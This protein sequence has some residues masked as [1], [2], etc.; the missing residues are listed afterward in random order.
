MYNYCSFG[1]Q[2]QLI[3]SEQCLKQGGVEDK[4]ISL[5]SLEGKIKSQDKSV[6]ELTFSP[7]S[8]HV[9]KNCQILVKVLQYYRQ[10]Y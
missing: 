7:G 4:I 5:S 9:L 1:L 10:H 2:Y 6:S 3:P 8:Q